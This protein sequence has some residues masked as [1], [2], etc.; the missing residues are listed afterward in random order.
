MQSTCIILAGGQGK[1]MGSA[2]THKVCF[3][4]NGRPAIVRALDAYKAAGVSRFIVVVGARAAD[5]MATVAAEHPD[6]CFAYQA[7]ALGTGHAARIGCATL[8]AEGYTGRVLITMGDKLVEPAVIRELLQKAES[9]A[10]AM[11]MVTLPFSGRDGAGRVLLDDAGSILGI[12]ERKDFLHARETASPVQVGE[13]AYTVD[14]IEAMQARNNGSIYLYDFGLLWQSLQDLRPNNRQGELYL[15]DTV[16]ALRSTGCGMVAVDVTDPHRVMA[17]NTPAELLAIEEILASREKPL[18]VRPAS[19]LPEN[20]AL[21][22]AAD[23]LR[24]L[25][26]PAAAKALTAIY[27]DDKQVCDAQIKQLAAVVHRFIE[28]FGADR[29]ALICRAPG[30]INLMG[31]HIEHRG[32]DINVMAIS[33]ETVVMAAPRDDDSVTLHNLNP[34]FSDRAFRIRD[35]LEQT[36]WEDWID[37]IDSTT[38]REVL[39]EAPGDWS[40]YARAP[41]LRLQH[42]TP[43][44]RLKGMDCV[45]GSN[46]PMG[47]G[48]SSS[49]ALVVSFAM[50]ATALNRLDIDIADFIDLCGE[51]EWFVGSR[52]GSGDHAAIRVGKIGSVSHLGFFPFSLK[53][54]TA[55][56]ANLC[57]VVAD[58]AI[59]AK[60]SAGAKDAFNHRIAAYRIGQMLLQ[61]TWPA[62]A[63]AT[64]LRDLSPDY[65]KVHPSDLYRALKN[66]PDKPTRD[67]LL[68]QANAETQKILQSIFQSHA[69]IA[70]Y[71]LRGV[72]LYG[73]AECARSARFSALLA[74]GDLDAIGRDM[75]VS[76]DGDRVA[77]TNR[78]TPSAAEAF[79][80]DTTDAQ[81]EKLASTETDLACL[82][83]AYACSTPDIDYLT[84]L[85]TSVDGVVG[86]QLSGAGLGGCIMILAHREALPALNQTLTEHYYQPRE[87]DPR[88]YPCQPVQGAD[89]LRA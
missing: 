26:D 37:F 39:Q 17:F 21:R 75:A 7:E 3:P 83:G 25:G 40:H 56:P 74:A 42:E 36:S 50:T 19:R 10:A 45:I 88:I 49:S 71:D 41:L 16:A 48:L 12:I 63:A 54:Q 18:R 68:V 38:V 78:A 52:G 55:F 4:V 80:F 6:V 87:I 31:R 13:H 84:D 65:L 1:R 59:Q 14:Q 24:W 9:S 20:A 22:P 43:A 30:R 33:R 32:G 77:H 62:A 5:V 58:S 70:P 85:A 57:L 89:L 81:L 64:H 35:L 8:A 28:R 29:K 82:P 11:A 60:K 44:A 53:G 15:T 69:D 23:W 73:L 51:G 79:I 46:I 47:A 72:V 86:A 27:G 34:E 61:Q 66:I 67:Q 76:H 2:E